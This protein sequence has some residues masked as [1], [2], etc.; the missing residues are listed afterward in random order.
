MA[1]AAKRTI[2]FFYVSCSYG[3]CSKKN[4][5]LFLCILLVWRLQQKEQSTF[6]MYL[7][8]MAVAA[9]R[10]IHFFYVSC[11]YGGCSKK[12][13]PLFLCILLVWRLQQKEQST[14][15]MYLARMAVAAKRTIPFFYVSCSY[16]GCS[17]KNN[18][19]FLCILLVWRLQQKEQ[20]TFFMYLARMAVAAKRT[21]HFFYVSCSYGGCSKKNNPLF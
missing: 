9:K 6:L 18:P 21:I 20:S 8:R 14:F 17:K 5:P 1:V 2:H 12:N 19:L 16:G 7:A 3:G 15:L 13:N 4:N 10:T 11:S